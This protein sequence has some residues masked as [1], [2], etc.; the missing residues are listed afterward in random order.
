[1]LC[2]GGALNCFEYDFKASVKFLNELKNIF[3]AKDLKRNR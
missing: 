2:D 1:M 3:D